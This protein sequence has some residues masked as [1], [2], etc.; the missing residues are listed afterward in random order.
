VVGLVD[1]LWR[2]VRAASA[3]IGVMHIIEKGDLIAL[4]DDL[5]GR[6]R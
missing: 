3:A 6:A 1:H 5:E 4:R 2:A